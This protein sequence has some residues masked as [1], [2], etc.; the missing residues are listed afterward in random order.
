MSVPPVGIAADAHLNDLQAEME[1]G[2]RKLDQVLKQGTDIRRALQTSHS[3]H[4]GQMRLLLEALNELRD[5]IAQQLSAVREL[6]HDVRR[7]RKHLD[8]QGSG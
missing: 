1:A 6:R 7:L 8:R 5:G 2:S 3:E 4:V